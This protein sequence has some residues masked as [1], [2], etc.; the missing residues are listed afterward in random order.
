MR[1]APTQCI[2]KAESGYL[3]QKSGHDSSVAGHTAMWNKL[4][5][6]IRRN[7]V[8]QPGRAAFVSCRRWYSIHCV[9]K[10][11]QS[12]PRTTAIGLLSCHSQIT[13]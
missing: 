12:S 7:Q 2:G 6:N 4:Q 3:E 10:M 13:E 8:G 5:N 1:T 9:P 11:A